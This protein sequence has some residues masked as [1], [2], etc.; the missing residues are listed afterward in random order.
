VYTGIAL[1]KK[2]HSWFDTEKLYRLM[3]I[4]NHGT[5]AEN[6]ACI[7]RGYI[8]FEGAGPAFLKGFKYQPA[9]A[10][11]TVEELIAI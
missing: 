6:I 11:Q 3:P 9:E 10:Q 2:V 7:C 5:S 1:G 4:Q 8:E